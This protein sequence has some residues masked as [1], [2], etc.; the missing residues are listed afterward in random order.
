MVKFGKYL[1]THKKNEWSSN[2]IDY[3]LLKN[4]IKELSKNQKSDGV[5]SEITPKQQ[6]EGETSSLQENKQ[7]GLDEDP[8][9]RIFRT[10]K[11]KYIKKFLDAVESEMTKFFRFFKSLEDEISEL[12]FSQ[13]YEYEDMNQ[14][15]NASES[16]L[17]VFLQ[18]IKSLSEIT[19]KTLDLC[20]FVNLNVTAIRKILKKFD[21]KFADK[22]FPIALYFIESKLKNSNSNLMTVLQ[23][24]I[25]DESSAILSTIIK[26]V[27]KDVNEKI[28]SLDD[29]NLA[30]SLS[31]TLMKEINFDYISTQI[32]KNKISSILNI[33]IK[34]LEERISS[35]DSANISIRNN[36][37]I[38][39]IMARENI[40]AINDMYSRGK[41]NIFDYF[42][43]ENIF[44]NL[45]KNYKNTG[46]KNKKDEYDIIDLEEKNYFNIWLILL[47]VL[48]YNMNQYIILPTNFVLINNFFDLNYAFSGIIFAAAPFASI[49]SQ[50]FY[51]KLQNS[52]KLSF[53]ISCLFFI[54]GNTLYLVS[55]T[56]KSFTI[57]IISRFFIGFGGAKSVVRKYLIEQIPNDRLSKYSFY[58]LSLIYIGIALGP[59]LNLIS[60]YFPYRE[61]DD[62]SLNI[63]NF[64]INSYTY[65][66][67]IPLLIWLIFIIVIVLLFSDKVGMRIESTNEADHELNNRYLKQETI[68]RFDKAYSKE[69]Q[70]Q[71]VLKKEIVEIINSQKES[72][73]DINKCYY[74]LVLIFLIIRITLESILVFAPI[75]LYLNYGINV[76]GTCIF[77]IT[78]SLLVIP[79]SLFI[80]KL[81][82]TVNECRMIFWSICILFISFCIFSFIQLEFYFIFFILYSF[83]IILSNI[84]ETYVNLLYS[85]II[86]YRIS[87]YSGLII[88][89]C[90]TG[91][92]VIGSLIGTV[93][94]LF[95]NQFEWRLYAICFFLVLL[96]VWKNL[97]ILRVTAIS[98]IIKKQDYFIS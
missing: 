31:K 34:I 59:L 54:I 88:I 7:S 20:E 87:G 86:S 75:N 70:I 51:F 71:E 9:E 56:Y 73:S 41:V 2:Y 39:S 69:N 55:F 64:P 44:N 67:L 22:E 80:N 11:G 43:N 42:Q 82:L 76:L 25:I 84:I 48:F 13:I 32:D 72:L 57:M 18:S 89:L 19:D 16:E 83:I 52:F 65:P 23:F 85:Q 33:K 46:L 30:N 62:Q 77:L 5:D 53:L 1:S 94:V 27:S 47:H 50:T 26:K 28:N 58:Y 37:D 74:I 3:T 96:I 40:K 4:V 8:M 12:L 98:R 66:A 93:F 79:L 17:D 60:F 97:S 78:T 6:N 81:L 95:N 45:T 92:K 36:I 91:G 35:V 14:K 49:F 29:R 61:I 63:V 15:L 10:S 21:K 24:K 90:T 68:K 38:W